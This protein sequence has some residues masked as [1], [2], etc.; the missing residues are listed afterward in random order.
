MMTMTV[1]ETASAPSEDDQ[2]LSLLASIRT[3][4]DEAT[5]G[6]GPLFTTTATDDALF[7]LFLESLP[8]DRR[9][10]YT[11]NAC[12]R[13]VNRYGGLVTIAAD[14]RTTPVMWTPDEAPMF[15]RA[16][17]RALAREVA[18]AKVTGVF[19]SEEKAWGL[20]ENKS[21][22]APFRWRHMAVTPCATMVFRGAVLNASQ[23]AAEKGQDYGTLCR[24]L[25]EFPIDIVRQAHTLLTT[26]NLFRS[27]KC[28]G[29]A[30]WLLDLHEAR[31]AT[32]D[33]RAREGLTWRAVATAPVGFCHVRSGMIGTLLEDIQAGL[34]FADI[35]AKFDAKMDPLQYQRPQAPQAPPT[36]GNIKAAEALVEKLGIAPSLPRRFARLEDVEALWTPKPTKSEPANGGVF[37]HL[38]AKGTPAAAPIDH[39]AVTMTWEKFA[40]TVLPEAES[41]EFY[42]PS[43]HAGYMAMITAV[44]PD[45]P[46]ILQWDR[47]ERRNPVSWYVYNHG[48]LP[49]DWNLKA[50]TWHRVTAVTLGPPQWYGSGFSHQGERCCFLLDGARD[51][52]HQRSGGFFPECLKSELHAVRAT[53]EA[54]ALNA[55]IEGR[56]E[57]TACGLVLAKGG[58]WNHQF[59]V[60]S[61]GARI[62]YK[63]DRWD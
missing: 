24:G 40:R 21:E 48:S 17:V 31:E 38:K 45:A 25:A 10:H 57:A 27:E 3:R 23:T 32:K 6:G 39:P 58:R 20:P 59:R 7:T 60:T 43:T 52:R 41:I 26:G 22:K 9:Q 53:L 15:F 56:D 49:G 5:A 46:P 42:A 33:V 29:V 16:S 11:C 8:A 34:A 44:N 62:T 55:A 54:Y 37:G 50:N 28:I 35:K 19:L 2:Y 4:F 13:F 63:L 30:K 14:G 1:S 61:K 36:A 51:L 18:R 47:P 12:R